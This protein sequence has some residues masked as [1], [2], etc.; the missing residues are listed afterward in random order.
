MFHL[1]PP[2]TFS[3]PCSLFP[4]PFSPYLLCNCKLAR[5]LPV[6]ESHNA[7]FRA[8]ISLVLKFFPIPPISPM[9][10]GAAGKSNILPSDVLPGNREKG[11]T[12]AC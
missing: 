10:A 12:Y 3:V 2:R 7:G 6:G 5:N 11:N 9:K 8:K 4:V 1:P